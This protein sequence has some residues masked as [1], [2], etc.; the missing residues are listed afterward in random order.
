MQGDVDS[1]KA[2]TRDARER[3]RTLVGQMRKRT[4]TSCVPYA[5]KMAVKTRNDLW[6]VSSKSHCAFKKI[7]KR[8]VCK[9]S[10]SW[11]SCKRKT[12]SWS[13]NM[14]IFG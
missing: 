10:C 2:E 5:L 11:W 9:W 8:K 14:I 4:G 13:F 12:I 6:Y 3:A 7:D 1:C